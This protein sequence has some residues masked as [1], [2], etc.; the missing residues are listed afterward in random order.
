MIPRSLSTHKV[1][2]HI[3]TNILLV[4]SKN[5]CKY[6]TIRT[7]SRMQLKFNTKEM[8]ECVSAYHSFY[9]LLIYYMNRLSDWGPNFCKCKVCGKVFLTQ[10]LCYEVCSYKCWKQQTLQN[11]QEF[12]KRVRGN[13]YDHQYK[14]ECPGWHNVM[15]KAKKT[16]GFPPE[17]LAAMQTAFDA[18]KKEALRWTTLVKSRQSSPEEFRD[19][20]VLQK[21][22]SWINV[23]SV[24]S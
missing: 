23:K 4:F 2:L 21:V 11:K 7:F 6:N 12:D 18:F 9:P 5:L 3:H 8:I 17:R 19:W 1:N 13:G 22:L 15:N 20:I 16:P 24:I 10:S 14:N